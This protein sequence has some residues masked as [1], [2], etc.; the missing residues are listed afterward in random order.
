MVLAL[1]CSSPLLFP[2][3]SISISDPAINGTA[4]KYKKKVSLLSLQTLQ[5]ALLL[6]PNHRGSNPLREFRAAGGDELASRSHRWR[7]QSPLPGK[8]LGCSDCC[9]HFLPS[10][11]RCVRKVT[12][13]E[14]AD[15]ILHMLQPVSFAHL[16]FCSKPSH[17]FEWTHGRTDSKAMPIEH[18]GALVIPRGGASIGAEDRGEG[19]WL[20]ASYWHGA[21]AFVT[22][23]FAK[24]LVH[25]ME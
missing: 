2:F 6:L 25:M 9:L 19:R 10:Y 18:W 14:P 15:F 3:T 22:P 5:S 12:P 8:G 17:G 7:V 11:H 24:T 21:L 16:M 13:A 4:I 23:S 1:L 20:W